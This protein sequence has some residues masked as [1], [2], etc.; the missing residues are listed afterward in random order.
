MRRLVMALCAPMVLVACGPQEP[1]QQS[2][3]DAW[4]RLPAASGR[5]A[6]AYFTI[7]G[8]SVP[9]R[10]MGISSPLAVR[11]ELHDMTMTGGVMAMVEIKGGIDVPR[12]D[13]LTFKPGGKHGMLF[14]VS[15]KAVAGKTLPLTFS[16]ASGATLSY[17]AKLIAAGDEDP[18]AH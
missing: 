14:D 15:P 6:A 8:G 5:P 13:D 17:E 18:H 1:K 11:A 12:G 9:D 10:L 2:V 16:F 3:T 4:V 7:R